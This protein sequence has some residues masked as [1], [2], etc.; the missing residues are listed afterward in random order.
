AFAD[1]ERRDVHCMR[2]LCAN[3]AILRRYPCNPYV[4]QTR[5]RF[6]TKK[7]PGGAQLH[8]AP[9]CSRSR[10]RVALRSTRGF[11]PATPK[12]VSNV[13]QVEAVL[14]NKAPGGAQ[15]NLG[16]EPGGAGVPGTVTSAPAP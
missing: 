9:G 15:R 11:I 3:P 14:V 7:P 13:A 16:P 1:G 10:P 2:R 4:R 5:S 8:P 12:A 6:M